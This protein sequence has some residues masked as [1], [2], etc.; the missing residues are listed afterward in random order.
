MGFK[1]NRR[2]RAEVGDRLDGVF[3]A[4]VPGVVMRVK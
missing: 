1:S 3:E 2:L 4:D